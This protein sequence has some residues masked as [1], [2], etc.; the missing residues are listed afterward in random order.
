V[1]SPLLWAL[2]RAFPWISKLAPA[3]LINNL[4]RE[5]RPHYWKMEAWHVGSLLVYA[6]VLFFWAPTVKDSLC[7]WWLPFLIACYGLYDVTIG[8]MDVVVALG[9]NKDDVGGFFSI[10]NRAR[11]VILTFLGT[12]QVPLCFAIIILLWGQAFS[13]PGTEPSLHNSIADPGT[14]FYY[15]LVTFTTLGYGDFAPN[16]A[17]GK[18]IIVVELIFFLFVVGVR[19]PLAVSVMRVKET[20]PTGLP[21]EPH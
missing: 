5:P 3:N 2:D 19:L 13:P 9:R 11:W 20:G 15:S 4:G 21:L 6:A 1:T 17:A 16:Q 10:R 14:A 7:A 18:R 12:I 8:I